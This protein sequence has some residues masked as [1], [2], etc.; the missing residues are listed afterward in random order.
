MQIA[1]S[2]GVMQMDGAEHGDFGGGA[3]QRIFADLSCVA[4]EIVD[5]R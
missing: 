2:A 1:L 3:L 5:D 4:D